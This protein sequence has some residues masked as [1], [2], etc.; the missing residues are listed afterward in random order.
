VDVAVR[1]RDAE[2]V[3]EGLLFVHEFPILGS[4][5]AK[6]LFALAA[7]RLAAEHFLEQREVQDHAPSLEVARLLLVVCAAGPSTRTVRPCEPVIE[8]MYADGE[9]TGGGK[10]APLGRPRTRAVSGS[11]PSLQDPSARDE[12]A[13]RKTFRQK[14][15]SLAR[16]SKVTASLLEAVA[17]TRARRSVL[18]IASDGSSSARMLARGAGFS[19]D[20]GVRARH[21]D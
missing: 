20:A 16:N 3:H 2:F 9:K 12:G 15:R 17:A 21:R 8:C 5:T 6:T 1:A 10:I 11:S 4:L 14:A 7:A 18:P 13:L 19:G